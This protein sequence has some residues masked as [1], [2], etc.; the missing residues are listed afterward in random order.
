MQNPSIQDILDRVPTV[1]SNPDHS[2][3]V[4]SI[5]LDRMVNLLAKLDN[6]QDKIPPTVHFAGTNGKGSTLAFT[7]AILEEAGYRVHA[8]TSPHLVIPNERIVLGGAMIADDDFQ[9]YI[10]RVNTANDGGDMT[11]FELLVAVAFLAFSEH[12]GDVVL[13]ETGLG[14]RYDATNVISHPMATV[15]TPISLDHT[16][17]LGDTIAQIAGEKACIQKRGRPSLLAPQEKSALDVLLQYADTIGAK[18]FVCGQGWGFEPTAD[19]GFEFL[20]LKFAKPSLAGS[21]QI[22]NAAT[23]VA[24]T[25]ILKGE[26][27]DKITPQAMQD[28][29]TNAIWPARMQKLTS[30]DIFKVIGDNADV[31]LDGGHNP[32]AG[33]AMADMLS[34]FADDRPN[35]MI[36]AMV[37]N[38]DATGYLTPLVPHIDKIYTLDIPDCHHSATGCDL[39]EL[40]QSLNI[41]ASPCDGLTA[42]YQNLIPH[43]VDNPRIFITGSLYFAGTILRTHHS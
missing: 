9:S 39:S 8:F 15:I 22:T 41:D 10:A 31:W 19:G 29:V 34:A 12:R 7:R 14:G 42:V 43:M 4:D 17:I 33:Y 25:M 2:G 30:G 35:I 28:G 18:P 21:H 23:A 1:I 5:G 16:H 20:N 24:T 40:A 13:L 37:D 38:K 32:S 27:L 3:L 11:V 26:G 36:M 6:P